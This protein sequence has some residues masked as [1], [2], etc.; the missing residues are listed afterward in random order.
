MGHNLDRPLSGRLADA[1]V[2]RRE[3]E[4]LALVGEG[5][6]NAKIAA[7]LWVSVRTVEGHVS[8]LLRKLGAKDRW[9]LVEVVDEIASSRP[10]AASRPTALTPFIGR[11]VERSA[12]AAALRGERL[13]TA[14]GPG[15]IGKTRLAIEVADDVAD[16]YPDGVWYVDLVPAAQ[17]AMIAPAVAGVLRLGESAARTAEDAVAT[18][19][20]NRE[21]LLVLDNCEHVADGVARFAEGLL[22]RCGQ[23]S[24]LATSRARLR[25]PFE[26]VF[27]VPGLSLPAQRAPVGG[28]DGDETSHWLGDAVAL[29]VARAR[30]A[31]PEVS[32]P[33]DLDRIAEL[34]RAFDGNALAIEL[35]AARLPTLGLDGLD[36]GL[37]DRLRLLAGG[38]RHDGRHNSLRAV[39]DMSYELADPVERAVLRRI[40]VF[41]GPVGTG[42]AAAV[43]GFAPISAGDAA[44]EVA[45]ALGRLADQSLVVPVAGASMMRY[46]LQ[47]TVRQYGAE[48]L[49]DAGDE[50]DTTRRRHLEECRRVAGELMSQDVGDPWPEPFD[51][52][53]DEL[54]A[55][56]AWSADQAGS[57]GQAAGLAMSLGSLAFRRGLAEEAQ[58]RFEQAA[59]LNDR[60]GR[61]GALQHAAGVAVSRDAGDDALRLHRQAARA[62]ADNDDDAGAARNLALAVTLVN[63]VAPILTN[64]PPPAEIDALLA[65][66]RSR[67]GTNPGAELAILVAEA[68]EHCKEQPDDGGLARRAVARSQELG[69]PLLESAALDVLTLVQLARGELTEAVAST[70]LRTELVASLPLEAATGP[71]IHDA[72]H[73]AVA[74]HVAVGD[75]PAAQRFARATLEQPA[76][77]DSHLDA[78]RLLVPDA[79][80]GHWRPVLAAATSFRTRWERQGRPM[81]PTVTMGAE[82]VAMVHGLRGDDDERETWLRLS[83]QSTPT[84]GAHSTARSIR[85]AFF[86]ALVLLHRGQPDQAMRRMTIDADDARRWPASMWR[87]W[88]AALSAEASALAA[89]PNADSRID[90]AR[91]ITTDNRVAAALVRRSDALMRDE[92]DTLPDVAK[93]LDAAGC[94]YQAARTLVLAG[95]EQRAE[96]ERIL[97]DLGAAPTVW[98]P[99]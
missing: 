73:M 12:L 34:C 11:A 48:R 56:L 21:A 40:T 3:A 97:A 77:R 67:A 79:L 46:Q 53:A 16:R 10:S 71:E 2:S 4:V 90:R 32:T 86:D 61:A 13:V 89:H 49:R 57:R 81:I 50:D 93:D 33:Q 65:E 88:Y 35:A 60:A 64:V 62:A 1:G 17:P 38:A 98:P 66:A 27:L 41:V 23:V 70:R 54:R 95:G 42:P 39:L 72:Y 36:A 75:L 44:G 59:A 14:V 74:T 47:E 85:A 80:A 87:P 84:T 5:M 45:H 83:G 6:T 92:R 99:A 29:F 52:V 9:A 7:R 78:L 69:D 15:G 43:A 58:L 24:V 25:V 19:L 91:G 22:A 37:S 31:G 82:V 55:A 20:S 63:R 8:S 28:S 94:H 51:S 76:F 30:T 96:G 18:A 26:R 68:F